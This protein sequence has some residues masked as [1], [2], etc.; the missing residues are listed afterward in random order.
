MRRGGRTYPEPE[1]CRG[2]RGRIERWQAICDRCWGR[3]P[4]DK[5]KPIMD[6]RRDRAP[7]LVS[8]AIIAAVAWLRD[9]DPADLAARVTGER[10]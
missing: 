4:H 9:H 8:G 2:C 3:L 5:R 7:H 1:L 10:E 6:A